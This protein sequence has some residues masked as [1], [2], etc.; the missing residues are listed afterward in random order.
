MNPDDVE[1]LGLDFTVSDSIFGAQ[2]TYNL[3]PGGSVINVTGV[4]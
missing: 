2:R 3:L 1:D 4:Q